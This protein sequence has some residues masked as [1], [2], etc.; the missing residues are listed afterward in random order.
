MLRV[1][2]PICGWHVWSPKTCS[3]EGR[4]NKTRSQNL[5]GLTNLDHQFTGERKRDRSKQLFLRNCVF[6]K[7]SFLLSNPVSCDYEVHHGCPLSS[8]I[9]SLVVRVTIASSL[10][11]PTCGESRVIK[12]LLQSFPLLLVGHFLIN[13]FTVVRACWPVRVH[14]VLQ[15]SDKE[16]QQKWS[17]RL[18]TWFRYTK[19]ND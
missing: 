12:N 8:I 13:C 5:I 1:H 16:T 2:T 17:E 9:S 14:E 6:S 10:G 11:S 18:G 15:C 4:R 3:T 7:C 19:R